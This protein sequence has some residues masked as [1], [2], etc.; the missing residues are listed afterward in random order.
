MKKI[1]LLAVL[2]SLFSF[3]AF[4]QEAAPGFET[5]RPNRT[6]ASTW[7]ARG[8][9]QLE[10][11]YQYEKKRQSGTEQRSCLYPQALLRVGL[12]KSAELRLEATYRQEDQ[13]MA[14]QPEEQEKGLSTVRVGTKVNVVAPKGAVPEISVLAMAELPLGHG[15]FKPRHLAPD[16]K[17]L[18]TNDLSKKVKL[19]YNTGFRREKEENTMLDQFQYSAS[20]SW[21]ISEKL[22]VFDE[23]FGDKVPGHHAQNYLDGGVQYLL[24]PSLQIDALVGTDLSAHAAEV[25]VGGGLSV[26][27]PK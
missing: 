1:I 14:E 13:R 24:L 26:R 16:L 6:E 19:Q 20:L 18:F 17:L 2:S 8:Y 15:S 11:G 12:L 3:G 5:D 23:F 25:F 4:A 10:T 27:L 7:V 22:S 21:K 9:L